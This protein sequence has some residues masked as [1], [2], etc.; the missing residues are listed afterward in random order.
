MLV[1]MLIKFWWFF[2]FVIIL[3]W[4]IVI[5]F[6][7]WIVESWWVIMIVVWFIMIWLSVFCII[8][9]DWVLR[10]FVV[11]LS[12]KM[13]GFFSIVFVIVICCFWFVESWVLCFFIRVWYFLG[14]VLMNVCVFVIFVVLIILFLV[15]FFLLYFMFLYMFVVKSV[16]FCWIKFMCFWSDWRCSFWIF[17]LLMR[18]WFESG[19]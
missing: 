19:L 13:V 11:L 1:G 15:V 3:F 16:G 12:N 18:M 5:E 4:S 14:S 10:E 7:F 17:F 6:V 8:I 9:F 2:C